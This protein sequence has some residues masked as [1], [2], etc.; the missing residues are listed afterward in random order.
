MVELLLRGEFTTESITSLS[1][2]DVG[3]LMRKYKSL[4]MV[5]ITLESHTS[6]GQSYEEQ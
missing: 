5:T 3:K 2:N 6:I 1:K 4:I